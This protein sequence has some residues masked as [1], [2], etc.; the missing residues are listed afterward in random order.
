MLLR[1]DEQKEL[2]IIYAISDFS[3]SVTNI[4]SNFPY[5]HSVYLFLDDGRALCATASN[6]RRFIYDWS[7]RPSDTV[8]EQVL[9][10]QGRHM[11]LVGGLTDRDYPLAPLAQQPEQNLI[12]A[13][14]TAKGGRLVINLFE[15]HFSTLYLGIAAAASVW[16]ERM[17]TCFPHGIRRIWADNMRILTNCPR[18]LPTAS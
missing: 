10:Y 11:A 2:D 5:V 17:E 3:K 6:M 16:S 15:E 8:V 4:I 12:S 18:R 1:Y 9:T 14:R 7:P 13:I